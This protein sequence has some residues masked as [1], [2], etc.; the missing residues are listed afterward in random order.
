[1]TALLWTLSTL[2][3]V[4]LLAVAAQEYRYLRVRRDIAADRQPLFHSSSAFHAATIVQL[5]PGQE[6]LSAVRG[7]VEAIESAGG[8]VVYAGKIAVNGLHS[9]QLPEV[10][11]DA[12]VLAQHPS[13]DAY[14]VSASSPDVQKARSTFAAVYTQG[15]QRSPWVNLAV[16]I[17]LLALRTADIV[18]RHP[19]RYP[20]RKG[21]IPAGAPAEALARRQK[22]IDGLLA[23][24]EYGSDAVVVLN[25]IKNGSREERKANEGYGRQMMALMAEMGNGPTHM[26]RAVTVEGTAEFDSVVIVYYPG[27]EYFAE[28]VQSEFFSGIVGGKQLGDTLSSPTVPLLPH[29]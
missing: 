14:E 3:I 16:P 5:S 26:G 4:V 9:D 7:L 13:R 24:R 27:V 18:R 11:W 15:M 22:L 19:S 6:L 2:L 17:G 28:M 8:Q 25:F 1:M 21:E 10:E 23:N 20:F 12:F 29:L